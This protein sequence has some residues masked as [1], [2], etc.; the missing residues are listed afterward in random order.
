MNKTILTLSILIMMAVGS[1][2]FAGGERNVADTQTVPQERPF[3]VNELNGF[4]NNQ[5]ARVER[6]YARV[7]SGSITHIQRQQTMATLSIIVGESL[8]SVGDAGVQIS[9]DLSNIFFKTNRSIPS[10]VAQIMNLAH[11][12]TTVGAEARIS[13]QSFKTSAELYGNTSRDLQV[14]VASI[15]A[16]MA[17]LPQTIREKFPEEANLITMQEQGINIILSGFEAHG[18]FSANLEHAV[19]NIL[20]PSNTTYEELLNLEAQ[21][22]NPNHSFSSRV[23]LRGRSLVDSATANLSSRYKVIE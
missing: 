13:L 6:L 8:S 11:N 9:R 4:M 14:A 17:K 7:A 12:S 16:S 10:L 1:S 21:L 5:L 20:S 18:V 15:R 2:S 19:T 3:D 23:F 22:K